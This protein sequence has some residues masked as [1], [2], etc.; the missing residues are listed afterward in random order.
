MGS[1]KTMLS[2]GENAGRNTA[3]KDLGKDTI[4]DACNGD[5]AKLHTRG[6][7][8]YLRDRGQQGSSGSTRRAGKEVSQHPSNHSK[9]STRLDQQF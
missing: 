4:P 9:A 3:R 5:G 2:G 6:R 1:A 8:R 7:V